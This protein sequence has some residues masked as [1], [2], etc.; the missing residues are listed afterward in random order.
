MYHDGDIALQIVCKRLGLSEEEFLELEK[1][2]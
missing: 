1:N 2:N